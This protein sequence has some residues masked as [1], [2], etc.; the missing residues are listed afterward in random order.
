MYYN[1][2][3]TEFHPYQINYLNQLGEEEPISFLTHQSTKEYE[4]ISSLSQEQ[5]AYRYAPGKWTVAEVLL[6]VMDTER[7]MSNRALWIARG[8]QLEQPGFDQ[9]D[10]AE[11]AEADRYNPKS[12]LAEYRSLRESSIGFY[13][14]L[15]SEALVRKSVVSG[16]PMSVRTLLCVVAGHTT[17]HFTVLT[18][19]YL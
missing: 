12:L 1:L 11:Y 13:Q 19:K 5:L 2:D 9:D 18:E 6:H 10:F 8:S 4:L 16:A 7:V 15:S 17:H 14:H 3:S